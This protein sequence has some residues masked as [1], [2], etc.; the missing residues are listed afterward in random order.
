M[1]IIRNTQYGLLL[2]FNNIL[3]TSIVHL[4]E[5]PFTKFDSSL[6]LQMSMTYFKVGG[7]I[8]VIS[9]DDQGEGGQKVLK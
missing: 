5:S 1:V 3:V 2:L 8:F 9:I 7:P 6:F 4:W